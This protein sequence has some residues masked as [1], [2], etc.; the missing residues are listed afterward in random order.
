MRSQQARWVPRLV[1]S[2]AAGSPCVG[3][4][5]SQMLSLRLLLRLG[6]RTHRFLDMTR[7]LAGAQST[8]GCFGRCRGSG[9]RTLIPRA[10]PGRRVV[11]WTLRVGHPR[12]CALSI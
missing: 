7:G 6:G 1:R 11:R 10:R 5:R 8:G 3:M 4:R 9:E 12:D 2:L